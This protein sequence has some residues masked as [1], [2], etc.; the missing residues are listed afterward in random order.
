[1]KKILLTLA[2]LLSG[3]SII[4]PIPHDPV[5]FGDLVQVKIAVDKLTCEPKDLSAWDDAI[6]KINKLALYSDLRGDPQSNS[7]SQLEQTIS[8]ARDSK[9]KILCDNVLKINK[10]RID[11][12]ADAWK[13]R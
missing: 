8:K 6:S 11:V 7:I 9:S 10:T 12:A 13:G 5:M 3:C 2:V 1:M 4:L